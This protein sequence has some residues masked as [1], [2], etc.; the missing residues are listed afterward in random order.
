M[1]IAVSRAIRRANPAARIV[2]GG[3]GGRGLRRRRLGCSPSPGARQAFDVA[4]VHLRGRL[5][6][7]V[8]AVA[9]WRRRLASLGFHGPIWATEHGYPADPAYQW[10]ER[11]QGDVGQTRYLSRWLPRL[12]GAGVDRIF[13]TLRDNRGGPWATEGLISGVADP[14]SA[15]PQVYRKPVASAVREFAMTLLMRTPVARELTLRRS[16]RS[17][18]RPCAGQPPLRRPRPCHDAHRHRLRSGPAGVPQV[19]PHLH[20]PRC[21]E[22]VGTRTGDRDDGRTPP[23]NTAR[24]SSS[25]HG[26]PWDAHRR[27]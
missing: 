20:A 18:G 9:L 3:L 11:F 10:D 19:R 24:R 7:V 15:N 26:P 16:F 2:L 27:G 14:P 5:R 22:A 4:S 1:L 25:A 12:I 21:C 23:R 13:I 17:V 6:V 8:G